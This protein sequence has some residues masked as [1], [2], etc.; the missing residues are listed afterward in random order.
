[1]ECMKSEDSAGLLVA[2]RNWTDALSPAANRNFGA[3]YAAITSNHKTAVDRAR[4]ARAR[5]SQENP[6]RLSC[7][8]RRADIA[9]ALPSVSVSYPIGLLPT[10]FWSGEP[11]EPKL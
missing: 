7:R 1:M 6:A 3:I 5:F 9:A 8:F 4:N 2:D 11:K 10:T